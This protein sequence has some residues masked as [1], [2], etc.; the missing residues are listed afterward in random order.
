MII[1]DLIKA[2]NLRIKI[3]NKCVHRIRTA[4]GT[5]IN[6]NKTARKVLRLNI[7]YSRRQGYPIHE[8]SKAYCTSMRTVQKYTTKIST[9]Y[10]PLQQKR[11]R[12]MVKLF[13][14]AN[15]TNKWIQHI[16]RHKLT[17]ITDLTT[18]MTSISEGTKPP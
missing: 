10:Y 2:S 1:E 14:R 12:S 8:L 4:Q 9:I 18:I 15:L 3:K 7:L 13:T 11:F 16:I 17:A 5:K 6:K